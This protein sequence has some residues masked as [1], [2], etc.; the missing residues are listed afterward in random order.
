MAQFSVD[1]VEPL[2]YDFTGFPQNKDPKKKCT[3]Q[4]VIP[5]P[6]QSH[7]QTYANSLKALYEVS[8]DEDLKDAVESES[9]TD[10]EGERLAQIAGLT[11]A[12]CQNSPT[13]AELMQ[14]TP[15]IRTA[16]LKWVYQELA[17]PKVS[18]DATRD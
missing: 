14:L 10:K 7:L 9:A 8:T 2:E 16:F 1:A 6:T 4:G 3:G 12:L 17:D 13:K 11:A 15:R 18:S 5:E